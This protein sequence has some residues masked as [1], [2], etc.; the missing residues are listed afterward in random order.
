MP[1]FKSP[2]GTTPTPP[3]PSMRKEKKIKNKKKIVVPAVV[4]I[5]A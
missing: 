2:L 5:V 4:P 3:V 1:M